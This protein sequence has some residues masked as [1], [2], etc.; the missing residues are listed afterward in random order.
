VHLASRSISQA[1][2]DAPAGPPPST[3]PPPPEGEARELLLAT[4]AFAKASDGRAVLEIA[5][6]FAIVAAWMLLAR[7]LEASPARFLV[8]FPLGAFL[9]RIFILQHDCGHLSLF[10]ARRVNDVV[11]QALSI[12]T[13]I[14]YLPWRAEHDWHHQNQGRLGR[15][16][17]DRVNSPMTVREALADPDGARQRVRLINL[18]VVMAGGFWSLQ[19]KRK[20]LAGFFLFR[21]AFRWP[22]RGV[23]AM[24]ASLWAST[25]GHAGVHALYAHLFGLRTW[26]G[27]IFPAH[28]VGSIYG[29]L[30]FWVQ[31]NF[32]RT[33]HAPDARW[34]LV[35]AALE[36]SSF[37]DLGR[38]GAWVTAHIGLH[39]VHH[40]N[41][42]IPSYR[43]EEA[44]RALAPLAAV[45]P[46]SRAEFAGAFRAMFW[47]ED[48]GAMV[49]HEDV[50]ASSMRGGAAPERA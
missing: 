38:L 44:R 4:R 37:L 13:G 25:L 36:G 21:P 45:R 48:A 49:R 7:A 40:L 19:V 16:G 9:V 23:G 50:A 2:P 11:G 30:L 3:R 18:P 41:A 6:T 46:L 29:A 47:D 34:S 35:R 12:V 20:R 28:V 17:V 26:A 42:R 10:R 43:L 15:R 27:V 33:Y 31:H 24:R 1:S 32:E 14:A 39:H 5:L 8:T 22:V